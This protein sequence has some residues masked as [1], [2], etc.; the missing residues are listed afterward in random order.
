MKSAPITE[1]TMP[2]HTVRYG[3]TQYRATLPST[4]DANIVHNIKTKQLK[5]LKE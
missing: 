1:E 4:D 2:T 5:Q 3:T